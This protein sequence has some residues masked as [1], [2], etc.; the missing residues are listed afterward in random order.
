MTTQANRRAALTALPEQQLFL[1]CSCGKD[2]LGFGI[3]GLALSRLPVHW[4]KALDAKLL[5]GLLHGRV[6]SRDVLVG[7]LACRA[8]FLRHHFPTLVHPVVN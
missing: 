3:Q 1:L 7:F 5:P 2:G 6:P 4:A 8:L